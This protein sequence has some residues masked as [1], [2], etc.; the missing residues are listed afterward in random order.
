VS[1]IL[2]A[3]AAVVT[4]IWYGSLFV[5]LLKI[6]V[7]VVGTLLPPCNKNNRLSPEK[8]E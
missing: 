7:T 4:V 6:P 8:A 2:D 3:T 5:V 1:I